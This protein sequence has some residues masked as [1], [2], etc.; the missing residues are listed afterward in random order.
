MNIFKIRIGI[1]WVFSIPYKKGTIWLIEI[2]SFGA[3]ETTK[4]AAESIIVSIFVLDLKVI[5]YKMS[6]NIRFQLHS[7]FNFVCSAF[8]FNSILIH[9]INRFGLGE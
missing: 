4:S 9:N 8:L 5:L 6:V 2:T 7:Y 3:V 1:F